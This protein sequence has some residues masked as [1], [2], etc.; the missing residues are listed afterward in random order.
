MNPKSDIPARVVGGGT[1]RLQHADRFVAVYVMAEDFPLAQDLKRLHEGVLPNDH[2][3]SPLLRPVDQR[4]E[5]A[6]WGGPHWTVLDALTSGDADAFAT[7][8]CGLAGRFARP[9]IRPVSL[10]IWGKTALVVRC[11][12]DGLDELRSALIAETRAM[13]ARSPIAD[14]EIQ[15]A[16]WWI[17]VHDNS[18]MNRKA[19]DGAL[20]FYRNHGSPPLPSSR[21]FRL[22]FLVRLFREWEQ[23]DADKKP[24]QLGRLEYYLRQGEPPWYA[25]K[26]Q[27]HLTLAS[28][29]SQ[30]TDLDRFTDLLWPYIANGF[31]VYEPSC[32]AILGEDVAKG[33]LSLRFFDFLTARPVS[34]IRRGLAVDARVAFADGTTRSQ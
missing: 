13:V 28:G 21:H 26:M 20:G 7:I 2:P 4:G 30:P 11:Q 15:R 27:F 12:V 18:E 29:L 31:P 32:L 25:S 24:K 34:E 5:V 1:N 8:V 14:E 22:G 16:H 17:Q 23:A 6:A 3:L 10:A 33:P 9:R 19:L